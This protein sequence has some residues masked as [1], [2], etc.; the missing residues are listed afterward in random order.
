MRDATKSVLEA[1]HCVGEM[2][3]KA[4]ISQVSIVLYKEK[5]PDIV[6]WKVPVKF[7]ENRTPM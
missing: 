3:L 5:I 6:I 4:R 1:A 2:I 7:T